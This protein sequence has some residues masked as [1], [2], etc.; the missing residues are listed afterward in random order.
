[1]RNGSFMTASPRIALVTGANKGIGLEIA[2]QLASEGIIVYI[3]ARDPARGEAAASSLAAEG[4]AVKSLVLDVTDEASIGAAAA[5]LAATHDHLDI[6]VN[7]AGIVD[8]AD[9]PPGSASLDTVRRLMDTNFV[10][11]LGV[12]QAVLPLD[13]KS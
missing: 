4:L 12:T 9:A 7:N 8:P 6:L 11:A 13:R 10:G 2:R 5:V 1:Q 3:G